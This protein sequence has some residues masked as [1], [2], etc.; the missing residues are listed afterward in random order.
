MNNNKQI[1]LAG[2]APDTGNLGV[3]ALFY[4]TAIGICTRLTDHQLVVFDHGIDVRNLEITGGN[5]EKFNVALCGAK[6]GRRYY[7]NENL[8]NIRINAKLGGGI[9]PIAKRILKSTAMLDI[10]GG[11]SFTDLYGSRCFDAIIYPKLI[12][13]ENDIPLI[14]LPQTYGPYSSVDVRDKAAEIVKRSAMAWARDAE[15]FAELKNLL[16]DA[17]DEH[18]HYLGVDVAFLLPIK[19]PNIPLSIKLTNWLE[20]RTSAIVGINISGLIYN[21]PDKARSQ[22]GLQADYR[23]VVYKFIKKLLSESDCNI[24]FVPHVLVAET[25]V[26]SDIAA[27]KQV[28]NLLSETEKQRVEIVFDSYRYNQCEIKWVISQLDWFCGM[29]M[30]ATIASLSTGVPTTAIAYSIKTWR[31]FKTCGQEQQVVDPRKMDTQEVVDGLWQCW[32]QRNQ[33]KQSLQ[34]RL[35]EVLMAA[36][37]QM[38]LICKTIAASPSVQ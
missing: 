21:Q 23:E 20:K 1:L 35:P 13:I 19:A 25:H 17:F 3:S 34:E 38:D 8:T 37:Q 29:R 36:K 7:Q 12:A 5:D 9:N 27:C 28:L 26:E 15:S 2:A 14:L 11:D 16:G 24:V 31:V 6:Y 33:V 18:K 10:S 4:S 22:Y 32:L 30:H